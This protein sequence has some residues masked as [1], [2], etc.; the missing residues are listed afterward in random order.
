M[1]NQ[2]KVIL[3]GR[4][5]V[6]LHQSDHVATGGEGSI[7]RLKTTAVKIFTNPD[8]M[9]HDDMKNKIAALAN[10]RHPWI[11]APQGIVTDEKHRPVGYFMPYTD[12][13]HLPRFFTNDF[14][15]QVSFGNAETSDLVDKMRQVI[16]VAHDFKATVV[17]GNEYSWLVKFSKNKTLEPRIVDVDSWQIDRWPA[18]VIMPSIQ[19][20]HT[21]GFN[22]LS[23]WF[24]WGIVTFQL[25]TGIHP[26]KG[27]LPGYSRN[28]FIAR[29]KKNASVFTNGIRLNRAVRDFS[30]I[31]PKLLNWYEQTFQGTKRSLPPSPLDSG[32]TVSPRVTTMRVAADQSTGLLTFQRLYNAPVKN[33]VKKIYDCGVAILESNVL[34]NLETGRELGTAKTPGCEVIR[35]PSGWLVIELVNEQIESWHTEGR[36]DKTTLSLTLDA[37]GILRFQ[38]RIFVI[39]DQGL[40]ELFVQVFKRPVLAIGTSW[41]AMTAATKFFDG[42]GI[43]DTLGAKFLLLPHDS[44]MLSYVRMPE[45]DKL[46]VINAKAA[47]NFVSIVAIDKQGNYHKFELT[48]AKDYQSY[49]LWRAIVDTP[50]LVIATLPKGVCAT[51][52]EDGQLVIFVP[53]NGQIQKYKDKTVAT[54][55]PLFVWDDKVVLIRD[56][57]VC[58]ISVT[59]KL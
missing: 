11:V 18:K 28:D 13:Q 16:Q 44:N 33:P 39:T 38:N 48:L 56:G 15:A 22:E 31:P 19:D 17:D 36:G 55:E 59:Q 12:G 23:D 42:V 32:I 6:T 20:F 51:V 5:P 9:G 1:A 57:D 47:P 53:V 30:C 25:Y 45:L 29:M 8:K 21:K 58:R 26:Y 10:I 46:N 41:Q 24:S 7:Y 3:V 37:T 49:K 35:T 50:E 27:T 54:D 14:R 4:G 2:Q 34:I 52:V 43:Q 40:T